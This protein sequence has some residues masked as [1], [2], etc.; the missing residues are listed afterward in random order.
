MTEFDRIHAALPHDLTDEAVREWNG[1]T[2]GEAVPVEAKSEKDKIR[3]RWAMARGR[4][5]P[6]PKR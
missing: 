2:C 3:A 4:A 6:R 5:L 1:E